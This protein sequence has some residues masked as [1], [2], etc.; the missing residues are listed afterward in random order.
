LISSLLVLYNQRYDLSSSGARKM[1][2][3]LAFDDDPSHSL[4]AEILVLRR[5]II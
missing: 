5:I 2:M 1:M 3:M 4:V